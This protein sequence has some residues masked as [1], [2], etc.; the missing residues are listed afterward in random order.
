MKTK[1]FY[2]LIILLGVI[3]CSKDYQGDSLDFSDSTNPYIELKAVK[4][5]VSAPATRDTTF[6]ITVRLRTAIASAPTTVNYQLSGA[7]SGTGSVVIERNM[8]EGT[9]TGIIVP[10][11]VLS[12]AASATATL[13]LTS[14]SNPNVVFDLGRNEV[15]K[16][17][18]ITIKPK[19]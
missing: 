12:G 14:A 13:T 5:A 16:T 2:L 4:I 19:L 1:Y 9:K 10:A 6:S 15:G 8:I 3:S 7:L 18:T 11:G 17:A